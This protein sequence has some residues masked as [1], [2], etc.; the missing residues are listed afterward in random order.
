M[1]FGYPERSTYHTTCVSRVKTHLKKFCTQGGV[2]KKFVEGRRIDA[3]GYD[4]KTKTLYFC[5]I[6]V[7]PKDLTKAIT[8]IHGSF[9]NFKPTDPENKVIPVIA[10]PKKLAEYLFKHETGN[11]RSFRALCKTTKIAIW[12][13]EQSNIVQIQGPK[14]KALKAKTKITTKT[15][16]KRKATIKSKSTTKVKKTHTTATKV[17]PITKPKS[18]KKPSLIKTRKPVSRKPLSKRK[19]TKK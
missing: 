17:K 1:L 11:W 12:I 5:E 2:E 19:A 15:T 9:F 7:D 8:Q 14:P 16:T 18:R 6:K 4:K 10:I 3:W 13:I